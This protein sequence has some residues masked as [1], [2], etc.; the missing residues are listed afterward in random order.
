MCSDHLYYPVG[1]LF[2]TMSNK[3]KMPEFKVRHDLTG[4]KIF[5]VYVFGYMLTSRTGPCAAAVK[6]K[7]IQSN[8]SRVSMNCVITNTCRYKELL[9]SCNNVP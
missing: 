9:L 7:Q 6:E 2:E 3:E 4:H 1:H 5:S 8:K